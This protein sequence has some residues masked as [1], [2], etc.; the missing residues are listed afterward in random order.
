GEALDKI[1]KHMGN[2]NDS[3]KKLS[4]RMDAIEGKKA[5]ADKEEGKEAKDAKKDAEGEKHEE[6]E[7]GKKDAKKDA[8]KDEEGT[9]ALKKEREENDLKEN[10]GKKDA[11]KDAKK[12]E[13]EE[14]DD[15]RRA[16]SVLRRELDDIKRRLPV[17]LSE[18]DRAKFVDAQVKA[19]S[20]AQKFGKNAPRAQNGETLMGYR[21]RLLRE[22]QPHSSA[23]KN[24]DLTKINDSATLSTIETQVY[25]DAASAA[26]NPAFDG[27]PGLR[28]IK[29]RDRAGRYISKF[30]GSAEACWAPFKTPVRALSGIK[31][32][33]E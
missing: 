16:D 32:K 18:E 6:S 30:Y 8:K 2:I 29:E 19:D 12:D 17:E 15:S 26:L 24:A 9:E 21:K 13:D 10:D 33:F 3:V 1:L 23:W 27:E 31:T 4:E 28:E 11:K 25:A 22:F 7:D 20:V 14:R 5:D